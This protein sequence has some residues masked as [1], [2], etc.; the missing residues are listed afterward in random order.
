[1]EVEL[2]FK[3]EYAKS[4]RASCKGCK[5]NISQGSLRIAAMIQSA[6][7]DGKSPNWFHASCFFKKQR[8]QSVGDIENFENLR[9]EDQELIRKRIEESVSVVEAKGSTKK[10]GKKRSN[11]EVEVLKDFGVEHAKSGRAM[12]RG[13]EQKITKGQI[14]VKKTVY[15]TEVGMKYGGQALWHHLECFASLRAD[16]GWFASGEQ[17]PGFKA[18]EA[19][20]KDE[21]K[22]ILP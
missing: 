3:T 2:P 10:G 6:F 18:L 9:F 12:C 16:L 20:A 14:R 13:C 11:G 19:D 21:V 15:D 22:K 7:H 8:P 4:G 17:L 5:G 1:M